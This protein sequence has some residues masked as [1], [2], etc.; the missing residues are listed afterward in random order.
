MAGSWTETEV[1]TL[2]FP[3]R[4]AI[5]EATS[6]DIADIML[7]VKKSDPNFPSWRLNFHLKK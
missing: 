5:E 6:I 2:T 7:V 4:L 1:L 3:K